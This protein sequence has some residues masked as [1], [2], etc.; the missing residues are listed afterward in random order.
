MC[1]CLTCE[2]LMTDEPIK[3]VDFKSN[4]PFAD[5]LYHFEDG[6][7]CQ[8]NGNESLVVEELQKSKCRLRR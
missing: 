1:K 7:R 4:S 2:M 5:D 3:V 8:Y 6:Y